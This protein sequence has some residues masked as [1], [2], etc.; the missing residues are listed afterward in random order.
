MLLADSNQVGKPV[1]A[2]H[3]CEGVADGYR[4]FK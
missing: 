1:T 3:T 2:Q 4:R